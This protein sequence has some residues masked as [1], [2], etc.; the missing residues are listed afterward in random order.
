[1]I[2]KHDSH[3]VHSL[4]YHLVWTPKFRHAILEGAVEIEL[5]QILAQTCVAYDWLLLEVELMPDHVHL[6]VQANPTDNVS[7]IVRTLKS[8]SALHLFN[9][10]P[11]LKKQKF[12]GTGLWS[13]GYYAST[14]EHISEETVRKYIQNQKTKG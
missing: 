12:W 2:K 4:G 3:S 5:K 11:T 14:V 8:I 6:F 1:M 9:K 7:D 10:F 13:S